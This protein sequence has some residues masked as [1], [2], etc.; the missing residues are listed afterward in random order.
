MSQPHCS[1]ITPPGQIALSPHALPSPAQRNETLMRRPMLPTAPLS[2]WLPTIPNPLPA[3]RIPGLPGRALIPRPTVSQIAKRDA[4]ETPQASNRATVAM[5][6]HHTPTPLPAVRH[7]PAGP[8]SRPTRRHLP[9]SETRRRQDATPTP[10]QPPS[11]TRSCALPVPDYQPS[12]HRPGSQAPGPPHAAP[13]NDKTRSPPHR[14][15]FGAQARHAK[16]P[17][18]TRRA[19]TMQITILGGG[20]FLG[21]KLAAGWPRT[22]HSAA[23]RSPA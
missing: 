8:S 10:V 18:R 7:R 20:G 23:S 5:A 12:P 19:P 1:G 17:P 9:H 4:R 6:S 3:E 15:T 16:L 13:R 22:A 21:R 2:R 14:P 11:A